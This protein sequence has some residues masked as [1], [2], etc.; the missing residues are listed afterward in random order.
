[1][2][3]SSKEYKKIFKYIVDDRHKKL[4]KY[5]KKKEI[6]INAIL[7][8]KGEKMVHVCCREG[9][10]DCLEYLVSSGA[11]VNLVDKSGNLP[12]HNAVRYCMENYTL[13][14]ESDLVSF[15]LTYSSGLLNVQNFKRE[16]AK[17]LIDKLEEMK[18]NAR[19]V[20]IFSCNLDC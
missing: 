17:E 18:Q 7:N 2:D 3:I 1:M 5:I 8:S 12:I 19:N 4:K 9:A 11:K 10:T 16:T 13:R 20:F 15:L 14:L 6:S